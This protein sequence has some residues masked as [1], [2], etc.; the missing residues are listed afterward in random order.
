LLQGKALAIEDTVDLLTLKDNESSED[1]VTSLH[2]L[3]YAKNLPEAR[4]Q[5]AITTVWRRIYLHDDWAAILKT[6][7]VSDAT[8]TERYRGTAL[9][10]TLFS[11]APST[12]PSEAL[13]LPSRE[14]IVSRWPGLSTEEVESLI[15]DYT[16][17]QDQLGESKLD[18]VYVRIKELVEGDGGNIDTGDL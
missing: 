13:A 3:N 14:E 11:G 10:F 4:K 2:L 7:D 8:L 17:E 12:S 6:T 1:Y 5:S 16:F 18:D 15:M 9:Y